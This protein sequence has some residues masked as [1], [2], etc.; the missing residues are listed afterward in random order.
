MTITATE[1][2]NDLGKYLSLA[3][4]EEIFITKNGKVIVKMS[5]P[6]ED[7]MAIVESLEGLIPGEVSDTEVREERLKVHE[8][9]D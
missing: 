9:L 7:K 4:N 3:E 8:I 5:S 2:K 1:L 6:Y